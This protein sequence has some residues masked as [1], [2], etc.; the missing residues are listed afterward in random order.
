MA[1]LIITIN[2]VNDVPTADPQAVNTDEDTAI[3]IILTGADIDGDPLDYVIVDQPSHGMLSG[4]PPSVSYSPDDDY[5]GSDSF[6]FKANDGSADSAIAVVEITIA[7]TNDAPTASGQSKE[8]DEDQSVEIILSGSDIDGDALSYFVVDLP[9]HGALSGTAPKFIY[10]PNADY[11]GSD[12]FTFKANDGL[13]DS[14]AATVSLTVNPVNDPPTTNDQNISLD[15]DTTLG[16]TLT[17]TD[18]E[19]D[20]LTYSVIDTPLHGTLFGNP[21]DLIYTPESNYNGDDS[22]TFRANDGNL[23]SDTSTVLITINEVNDEPTADG[24]AINTDEDTTIDITLTGDDIDGDPLDY[25]IVDTPLHGILYGNPPNVSYTPSDDYN[26]PDSFTFKANDGS[27]DSAIAVVE[28]TIEPINDAPTAIE[29]SLETNEDIPLNITLT[30]DDLDGDS[31]IYSIVEQPS[32]GT[33]SGEP[34]NLSYSPDLNYNGLDS[35]TFKSNDGYLNSIVATISISVAPVND[36]PTVENQNINTDEDI[37]VIVSLTG[38]DIED[39]PLDYL[40]EEQPGHGILVETVEGLLYIPVSDYNG[41]DSFKFKAND[42]ELD[43]NIAVFTVDIASVNDAPNATDGNL[44]TEEDTPAQGALNALDI[45]G[46]ALTYSIVSQP[47]SGSIILIDESTGAYTFKPD[48]NVN[49]PDNFTFKANDGVLDSNTAT[50]NI[51]V[52]PVNDKP[53]ADAQS[54]NTSEDITTSLILTGSDIDE[55][56]LTFLIVE[57]PTHGSLS[58]DPPNLN[59]T[60]ETDYN[61]T[62]SFTFK[63]NDGSLD[64]DPAIVSFTIDPVNDPPIANGQSTEVDED[65]SIELTLTG[66]DIDGDALIYSLIDNP[67]NGTISGV[68]PNLIYTPNADFNGPDSFTFMVNDSS[69]DSNIATIS[70][71]VNPVNDSPIADEQSVST[72]ED[73]SVNITLTGSDIEEDTLDY[74]IV[75]PPLHGVLSGEPPDM[76]YIP[77][78]NYYGNDNF[79]FKTNDGL[80]DSNLASV[81]ITINPVNDTPS[82]DDQVVTTDEDISIEITLVGSDIDENDLTFHIIDPPLNGELSGE[83]PALIYDPNDDFNGSDSFTF[84]ANDG[85]VDS[86]VGTVSININPINDA[87][88]AN[89]GHDQTTYE[90]FTVILNGSNSRDIDDGIASYHWTQTSGLT[91]TLSD[92][93]AAQTTFTA[94]Y[95][96]PTGESL[97]FDL[98]TKDYAGLETSDTCIIYVMWINDPPVANAGTDQIVKEGSIVMLDGSGSTDSDNGIEQYIWIQSTGPPVILSDV[99]SVNPIFIAPMVDYNGAILKFLLYI[100]DNGGFASSDTISVKVA[101]AAI[102]GD[103]DDSGT[104]DLVDVI[105]AL[106]VCG[107]ITP[108]SPIEISADIN[109]DGK[110]GLEEAIN[111]LQ[112]VSGVKLD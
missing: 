90:G 24:Q 56:E 23:D 54:L 19:A 25:L 27:A 37:P 43:S 59:Y 16:V 73:T 112:L 42:G 75:Y 71:T 12:S 46:D 33:I 47:A 109:G 62:D 77:D 68:N 88:V 61:G 4:N 83:A 6:S 55:D 87:P 94:P 5:N 11:N 111:A 3:G 41:V 100:I 44:A 79:T 110:I 93:S 92:N 20:A 15:E 103:V 36:A 7:S 45:D 91:V 74:S 70:I 95:V 89:A 96:G 49:G 97:T 14:E 32:K 10:V 31:L 40:I 78:T 2:G 29:Q 60:P 58:G 50:V 13:I 101:N 52:N 38:L 107:G 63:A 53:V 21:P 17:G 104:I 26:G 105:L 82:V 81:S 9:M 84:K 108:S 1:G 30:G 67:L 39:D 22:F 69:L 64:S 85:L 98:V 76:I 106:Q 34:P 18:I 86:N 65:L 35:F 72:D 28:I 51:V 99:A 48:E 80:L 66:M 57:A 8:T 102:I